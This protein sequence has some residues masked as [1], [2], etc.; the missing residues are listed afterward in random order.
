LCILIRPILVSL[1]RTQK[2]D[3]L[4][5]DNFPAISTTAPHTLHLIKRCGIG[6]S[7]ILD[8]GNTNEKEQG[9][10]HAVVAQL[11]TLVCRGDAGSE[12]S[13]KRQ[14]ITE[15]VARVCLE[16]PGMNEEELTAM[17]LTEWNA[18]R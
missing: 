18:I 11:V 10:C 4:H 16:P 14:M 1:F 15:K 5:P 8:T 6:S 12:D 17:I 3:P 13:V 2:F 7:N 9:C